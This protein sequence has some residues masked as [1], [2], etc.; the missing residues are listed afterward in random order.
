MWCR[1]VPSV[2]R[3]LARTVVGFGLLLPAAA[4]PTE[5]VTVTGTK[6]REVLQGFVRSLTKPTRMSGKIARWEDGICPVT[7]GL[8]PEFIQF[9]DRRLKDVAAQVGAPVGKQGCG[10]NIAIVFTTTPQDL[11]DN[12]RKKRP[13]MLGYYDNTAQLDKLA[14]VTHP[15]QAWYVT[16]TRDVNGS[17]QI[18][19]ARPAGLINQM[20]LPCDICTAGKIV[21]HPNQVLDTTGSRL[22]DGIHSGL[23]Y[24][25]IVADPAQLLNYGMGSLAD[26]IAL[27]TLTQL[28]SL[29]DCQ[30]LPSVANMLAKQCDRKSDALTEN[31]TAYLRGLYKMGT[32][33]T[34]RSQRDE[35]AYQMEQN[36][37]AGQTEP[38]R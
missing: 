38:Q 8:K 28:D 37:T 16:D 6:S 5:N 25:V 32:G 17:V 10:A 13:V 27:L 35:I 18:D 15:I 3:W 22:G 2:C 29:D 11:I 21:M 23:H 4:Q 24:V 33:R 7:V 26:Y 20:E 30:Q 19:G 34:L 31:D 9:I 36:L 12:V 14:A 1:S